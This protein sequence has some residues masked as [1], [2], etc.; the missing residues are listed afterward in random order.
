M[1]LVTHLLIG[2]LMAFELN[3]NIRDRAAEEGGSWMEYDEGVSF[4]VAR[5]SNS[6][7]KSFISRQY[8][9]NERTLAKEDSKMAEKLSEKVMLEAVAVHLLLDWKGVTLDGKLVKYSEPLAKELMEEHDD[10]RA[11]IE[12]Y[13]DNRDNYLLE[14]DVKDAKNLKK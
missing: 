11:D 8:R 5:K 9:E 4:L 1:I 3:S 7:Y 2:V 14:K 13:A 10:L 6:R 12:K